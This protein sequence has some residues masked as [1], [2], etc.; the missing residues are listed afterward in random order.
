M[1]LSGGEKQ[2]L[3]LARGLFF[4]SDRDSEIILLDESTSSVDVSNERLIYESVL[5]HFKSRVVVSAV[6]KFNLL[7]LFDEIIVMERGKVIERGSLGELLSRGGHFAQ[8]WER[9]ART[10]TLAQER[11]AG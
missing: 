8:L 3:A 6:H 10:T 4:A 2:R 7:D 9:Y 11:A 5:S 1:S